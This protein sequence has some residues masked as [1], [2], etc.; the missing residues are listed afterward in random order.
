MTFIVSHDGIVFQRDF[1]P[2]TL[3]RFREMD[4]YDPVPGWT[5]VE[6]F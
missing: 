2:E 4:R 6:A 3:D 5:P 1:G